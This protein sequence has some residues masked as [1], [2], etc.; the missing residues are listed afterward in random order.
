[1]K[2]PCFI[3]NIII[4]LLSY[5]FHFDAKHINHFSNN[6]VCLQ[7]PNTITLYQFDDSFPK[8]ISQ[9]IYY[10]KHENIRIDSIVL[11]NFIFP[12][13]NKNRS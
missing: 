10:F 8:K 11:C 4:I 12:L 9:Q 13:E 1:M 3:E 2:Q 6:N 7:I 5:R